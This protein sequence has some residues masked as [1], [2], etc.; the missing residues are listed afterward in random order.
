VTFNKTLVVFSKNDR[1]LTIS[2]IT[3]KTKQKNKFQIF[4]SKSLDN[5]L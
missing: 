2:Q 4:Q 3:K 5:P 1:Q